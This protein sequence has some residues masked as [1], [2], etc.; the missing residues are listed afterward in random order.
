MQ[1]PSFTGSLAKDISQDRLVFL[2]DLLLNYNNTDSF[3]IAARS[4][5]K[6]NVLIWTGLRDS[7]PSHLKDN[8]ISRSP[9]SSIPSF[10]TGFGDEDFCVNTKKS[11]DYYSL[12]IGK[13]SQSTKCNYLSS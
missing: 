6:S 8:T 11:R 9:S 13:K 12:L 4:I 2:K 3:N 5:E 10:S 7:V 1:P